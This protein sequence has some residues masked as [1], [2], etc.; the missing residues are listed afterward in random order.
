MNR[1]TRFPLFL[2][3]LPFR[4]IRHAWQIR[5]HNAPAALVTF[6]AAVGY[7]PSVELGIVVGAGIALV[8]YLLPP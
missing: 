4:A 7:A 1:P 8:L 2:H 3:W 6:F 5:R